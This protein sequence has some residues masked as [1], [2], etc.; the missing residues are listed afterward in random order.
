MRSS[1]RNLGLQPEVT[2][3][4]SDSEGHIES[5][6]ESEDAGEDVRESVEREDANSLDEE[7][8][9]KISN[10]VNL[11]DSDQSEASS[12]SEVIGVPAKS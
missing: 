10:D 6:P 9:S 11:D 3:E 7:E 2:P 4:D 5:N 12:D 1:R 8:T